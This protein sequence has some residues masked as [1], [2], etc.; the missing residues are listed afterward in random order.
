MA[1]AAERLCESRFFALDINMGCPAPKIVSGGD[2][3]AMLK[4]LKNAEKVLRAVVKASSLPVTVKMRMGWDEHSIC[5]L[6]AGKMAQ[7]CGV[8]AV[9]LHARTRQEM[10]AGHAHWDAIGELAAALDIPVVGNGDIESVEDAQRMLRETGC[11]AVMIGRGAMGNPWIFR[12]WARNKQG[13]PPEAVALGERV[14]V[15]LEHARLLMAHKGEYI[16]LREMRKHMAWYLKGL[17]GSAQVRVKFNT[18]ESYT[19]MED[20]LRTYLEKLESGAI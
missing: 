17:R 4:D 11:H 16:G 10:Y 12:D 13:L 1:R 20:I 14:D 7:D 6:E 2:G 18:A 9:T 5:T 3:S 8:S 15:A 19:Q